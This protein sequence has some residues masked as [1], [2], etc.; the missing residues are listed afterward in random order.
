MLFKKFTGEK[1]HNEDQ[2]SID[3]TA[4]HRRHPLEQPGERG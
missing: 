4:P 3:G 2:D 1:L